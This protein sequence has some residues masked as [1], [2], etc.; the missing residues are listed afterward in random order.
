M[1]DERLKEVL[2][3]LERRNVITTESAEASSCCGIARDDDGF[4]VHRPGHPIYV[5]PPNDEPFIEGGPSDELDR[6]L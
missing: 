1:S 2:A 5:E 4:C 3:T 6:F